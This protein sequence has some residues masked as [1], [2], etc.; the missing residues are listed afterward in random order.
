M[1]VT[2]T[3]TLGTKSTAASGT[4]PV[5]VR[6]TDSQ[7][8][9]VT[10]DASFNVQIVG[11]V[12]SAPALTAPANGATGVLPNPAFS[13]AAN[14]EA[15]GYTIEVATDSG[16]A[17]IVASG[18]PTTNSWTPPTS[19]APLTM[20]YWRVKANNTCGDSVSSATFSFT[21]GG[22]YTVGGTLNGVTGPGLTLKLNNGT[23]LTIAQTD[24]T[25][26]FPN[27]LPTSTAYSVTIGTSS[28]GQTCT[29]ANGTGT[30]GTSN[31]TN[32]AVNCVDLPPES[33]TLGG[34]V[35]GLTAPGLVLQLNGGL[36]LT[37]NSN[38]LYNFVPGLPPGASYE[39]TVM[40]QPAG[41]T[42]VVSNG[43]GTMPNFAVTDVDVTCAP[44]VV[45]IIFKDGFETVTR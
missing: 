8:T 26:V 33:H 32:V 36:T 44:T 19:L 1:S 28:S 15:A 3:L 38:G 13:W 35:R 12:P 9:P 37:Q 34:R 2:S 41:L 30:I 45:D 14:T 4:Y 23:P 43:T 11:G 29:V 6:G 20:H 17:N 10:H 40:T 18:T 25:F 31:V 5:L 22:S 21:T 16:F 27:S 7:A 42:C 24:T 39:V